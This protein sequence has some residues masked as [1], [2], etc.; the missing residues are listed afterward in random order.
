MKSVCVCMVMLAMS[1]SGMAAMTVLQDF[2]TVTSEALLGQGFN[3]T[4]GLCQ[5]GYVTGK[6][7]RVGFTLKRMEL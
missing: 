1:V 7:P 6:N 5:M 4:G 3:V 2:N